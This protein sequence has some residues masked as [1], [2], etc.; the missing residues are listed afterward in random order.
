MKQGVI[1]KKQ[2]L[3]GKGGFGR[4]MKIPLGRVFSKRVEEKTYI[5]KR[6]GKKILGIETSQL[7]EAFP[8]SQ[9]VLSIADRV[10]EVL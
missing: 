5:S 4:T 9:G 2:R 10:D 8:H 1:K 3:E 7:V 6:K